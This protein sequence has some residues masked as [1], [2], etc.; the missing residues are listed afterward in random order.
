MS[1][2]SNPAVL[3]CAVL[4]CILQE[5]VRILKDRACAAFGVE[6]D[7]VEIWDYFNHGKYAN[8]DKE[9]DRDLVT[10]RILDEQPILLDDKVG[11]CGFVLGTA[12]RVVGDCVGICGLTRMG[13]STHIGR[14][15]DCAGAARGPG[16]Q[17]AQAYGDQGQVMWQRTSISTCCLLKQHYV[18]CCL[19]GVRPLLSMC[20][21]CHSVGE[22]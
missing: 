22:L 6:P 18:C 7:K 4:C 20:V 9:L 11:G 8:L 10:A 2:A 19:Q 15:A 5:T 14:A 17:S 21:V 13:G 16:D 3:C 1:H 12:A